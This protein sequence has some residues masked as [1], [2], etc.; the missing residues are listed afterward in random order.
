MA[1]PNS[2]LIGYMLYKRNLYILAY[3]CGKLVLSLNILTK[4]PTLYELYVV[5]KERLNL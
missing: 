3:Q 5:V 4:P 2:N 1:T